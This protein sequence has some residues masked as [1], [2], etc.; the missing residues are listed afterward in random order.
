MN[1]FLIISGIQYFLKYFGPL[2]YY[3]FWMDGHQLNLSGSIYPPTAVV[4]TKLGSAV[5]FSKFKT[6]DPQISSVFS[7]IPLNILNIEH[8][9]A[10]RTKKLQAFDPME[11][12]IYRISPLFRC[13]HPILNSFVPFLYVAT[14]ELE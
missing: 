14:I 10:R 7:K 8:P 3:F 5:L 4:R 13:L 1:K 6:V 11:K 2:P 9:N 12:R